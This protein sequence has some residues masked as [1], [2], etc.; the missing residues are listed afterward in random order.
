[1]RHMVVLKVMIKSLK[2][3]RLHDNE[4]NEHNK[5]SVAQISPC[6]SPEVAPC[7]RTD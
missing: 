3:F 5:Y 6:M 4:F 1:L 2:S 7:T